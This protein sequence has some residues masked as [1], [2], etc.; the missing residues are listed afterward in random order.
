MIRCG[1]LLGFTGSLSPTLEMRLGIYFNILENIT[2][3]LGLWVGTLMRFF[4][5]PRRLVGYQ[6]TNEESKL[7]DMSL[8]KF[9]GYRIFWFLVY[10]GKG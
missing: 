1:N 9:D 4:S 6:E 2:I 5:L 3:F 10:L 7:F 8:T